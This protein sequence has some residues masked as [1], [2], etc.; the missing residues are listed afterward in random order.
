MSMTADSV[1]DIF[2]QAHQGSVAAIIQVLNDK[3]ADSGVRTRAI[4]ANGI[5]QLLCEASTK[6]QLEQT[7]LIDR[8]Q[9][10]LEAIEPRSVRR[11]NINSRIVRE[12]QLLWLEEINRDPDGQVL[13]SK[14]IVLKRKNPLKR[15]LTDW[16]DD[17]IESF[18][19]PQTRSPH[20]IREQNQFKK[21]IVG[22]LAV[23][24]G[25]LLAGWGVYMW[26]EGRSSTAPPKNSTSIQSASG[27]NLDQDN[28][29][30][31][32]RLAER[33]SEIGKTAQTPEQ[34]QNLADTWGK[35]SK[36]MGSVPASDK[37]YAIALDRT[38]LYRRY[39]ESALQ[40]IK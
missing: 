11:V 15:L 19:R 22:G 27:I 17:R 23:S 14:E 38:A 32:V 2:R 7:M 9:K 18:D 29:A 35:A 12:Q 1:N 39:Q 37:R 10:I 20:L 3:L 36:L 8:V 5:L 6:E 4:F 16:R 40:K 30:T 28:F 33:A 13:W 26:Q 21:G 31:A 34:W 25:L 24:A